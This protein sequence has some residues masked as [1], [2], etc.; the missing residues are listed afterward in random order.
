[1]GT[2][3]Q[4]G[5]PNESAHELAFESYGLQ[6]AVGANR[7]ELLDQIRRVLP[8]GARSVSPAGVQA[9]F[10]FTLTDK[11]SF[12][13]SRNGEELSGIESI[14]LDLALELLETQ[15][16]LYVG[17]RSPEFIFF[18]A[19]VVA[20]R[21]RA[22]VIP[23]STFAGK[24]TLV[25]AL[26]RAGAVYYSDEFAV[27]NRD[28]LIVPFPKPLSIRDDDGWNQTDHAVESFGGAA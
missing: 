17:T 28:G 8:P 25:A 19:G 14:D 24:T 6:V 11:N 27:V 22:I 13:L 26:V 23:A 21:G 15:L 16:R 7:A 9:R 5:G 20:H 2:A 18:H 12:T 3:E 4:N 1:M 10:D